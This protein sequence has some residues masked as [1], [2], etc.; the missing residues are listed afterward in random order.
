C[1]GG[2]SVPEAVTN[3]EFTKPMKAI[4]KPMPTV[5]ATFRACGTALK[6]AVQIPVAP[7]TTIT[8]PLMTTNPIA[9]GQVTSCT[10]ET[11]RK[12]F[13]PSPAA[14]AKGNLATTP[15]R[16]VITPATRPV[17]AV[18]C[19]K[20][21]LPPS[22]SAEPPRISGLSTTIYAITTNATMPPRIS[23]LIEEPRDVISKNLSSTPGDCLEVRAAVLWS[24]SI[25]FIDHL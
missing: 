12:L 2:L 25:A 3:P 24:L 16:I 11:A 23:C 19:A 22:T 7:R 13:I 1:T 4:N 21:R 14:K 5:I 10:T 20:S 15:K 17:T 9:S 8:A 18:S 6:I